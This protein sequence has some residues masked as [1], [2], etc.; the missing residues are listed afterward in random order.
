MT[1]YWEE[2]LASAG[3]RI[4]ESQFPTDFAYVVHKATGQ[5]IYIEFENDE[6]DP[7]SLEFQIIR[8]LT[9]KV[10]KRGKVIK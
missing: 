8:A 5:M 6:E 1:E 2:L 4:I 3:W 10:V 7:T 9:S